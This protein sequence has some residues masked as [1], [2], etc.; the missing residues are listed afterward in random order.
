MLAHG[1]QAEKGRTYQY[2]NTKLTSTF[3]P[4]KN[5][6]CHYRNLQLYI[7]HGLKVTKIHKVMRFKQ[8]NFLKTYIDYYTAKRKASKT[9]FAKRLYKFFVNAVYGKFIEQ[10]RNYLECKICTTKKEVMKN[11]T[12]VRFE[13]LKII[14]NKLVVIFLKPE[15]LVFNKAY[16]IGFSI[17]ELSK[18]FMYQQ[19][20]ECIRP[21]LSNCEV[22][23][24]DTDSLALVVFN[25]TKTDN[26]AKMHD[27]I[28]FSNYDVSHPKFNTKH[29]NTLGYW[30]DE[31]QGHSIKEYV[32][33]RAK[34]YTIK[35]EK[36]N[37]T[38]IKTT[39]KGIRK[40]YKKAIPFSK[41][42]KCIQTINQE[43]I[44]QYNIQSKSHIVNTMRLKK[45]CFGSFDDKRYLFNCGFHSVPYG[46]CYIAQYENDDICPLC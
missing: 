12:N 35:M 19:Y 24:S 1:S 2:S 7:K 37:K 5:Y 39:C 43:T 6:V 11:I 45:I 17:L 44:T 23:F 27:M 34:C 4:R 38:E 10:I 32:G 20:Y 46:S 9:P 14:S 36:R 18:L 21:R 29:A 30:K 15:K 40:G 16:P 41:F 25:E 42:R 33:L 13:S 3:L 31:L 28:D 8:S 26:I 22:L